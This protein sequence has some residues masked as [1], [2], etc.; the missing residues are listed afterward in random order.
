MGVL[1]IISGDRR[2]AHL[3]T[4]EGDETRPLRDRVRQALFNILRPRLRES[5]VLDAFAGSGAVGLEALS[6]GALHATMVEPIPAA[7]A[8][9]RDNVRKLRYEDR[10][11]VI[12][13]LTPESPARSPLVTQSF[14]LVFL[15]PPY[16]SGLGQAAIADI[17]LS[18]RIAPEAM[19]VCEVHRDEPFEPPPGWQ[20]SDDRAYGIT[21]L[22]FLT[23]IGDVN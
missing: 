15:M 21:R 3:R 1:R 23:R 11:L 18:R 8:A 2:G 4:P 5:R 17:D 16:H 19:A 13:G 20:I 9:I 14:T 22:A 7:V 10:A 6:N 12:Q